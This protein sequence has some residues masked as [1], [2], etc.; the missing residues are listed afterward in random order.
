MKYAC[1]GS[2][3]YSLTLRRWTLEGEHRF[4][5]LSVWGAPNVSNCS[6]TMGQTSWQPIGMSGQVCEGHISH[7]V[8]QCKLSET[9]GDSVCVCMCVC[10]RVCVRVMCLCVIC[11]RIWTIHA[12]RNVLQ[13]RTYS[14]ESHWSVV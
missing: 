8:E 2:F 9:R 3:L 13:H 6:W 14:Q 5:W 10:V 12:T 4:I 1:T 11:L 7:I